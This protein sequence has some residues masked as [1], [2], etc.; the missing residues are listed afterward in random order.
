MP[1]KMPQSRSTSALFGADAPHS[2][3]ANKCKSNADFAFMTL[4][5]LAIQASNPFAKPRVQ[6]NG[7]VRFIMDVLRAHE[8]NADVQAAGCS[9]LAPIVLDT[10]VQQ[11]FAHEQDVLRFALRTMGIHAQSLKVQLCA[12][13]LLG[14]MISMQSKL[15]DDSRLVA[16]GKDIIRTLAASLHNFPSISEL[17]HH[18][19]RTFICIR[20]QT[21]SQSLKDLMLSEQAPDAVL[22]IMKGSLLDDSETMVGALTTLSCILDD[23]NL[24]NVKRDRRKHQNDLVSA[25]RQVATPVVLNVLG[26]HFGN[27]EVRRKGLDLL[28]TF[29]HEPFFG[30]QVY[31]AKARGM[32]LLIKC[33]EARDNDKDMKKDLYECIAYAT[34]K[35]AHN[36]DKCEELGA[37]DIILRVSKSEEDEQLNS[38]TVQM[39]ECITFDHARN[40]AHW[41]QAMPTSLAKKLQ[42]AVNACR[43]SQ[44]KQDWLREL[45]IEPETKAEVEAIIQS[46][47]GVNQ[48]VCAKALVMHEIQKIMEQCAGCGKTAA[49]CGMDRL[50]RCSAC[51]IATGYCGP[52]CQKACWP[53]HKAECKAN[54]KK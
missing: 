29:S 5:E 6:G 10:P 25:F 1:K 32:P 48:G 39:L 26:E 14:S 52:E 23:F 16:E 53:G 18:I 40:L 34:S 41:K 43:D 31:Q 3:I 17:V 8:N 49:S 21:Q 11:N 22:A 35:H 19:F 9:A 28:W 37:I 7:A 38:R 4:Q 27:V 54:R 50:L 15:I 2:D 12:S 47:L 33:L 46:G 36:K 42:R 20:S 13:V 45:G 44:N 51:T 30:E 24:Y